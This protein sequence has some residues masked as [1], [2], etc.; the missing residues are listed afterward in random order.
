MGKP[1]VMAVHGAKKMRKELRAADL[2]LTDLKVPYA[3]AAKTIEGVAKPRTPRRSGAL[4]GTVRSSGTTTAGIVRAGN[5]TKVP[6]AQVIHWGWKA[7]RIEAQPW[8]S[9]AAQSSEPQ[10]VREFE[11]QLDEAISQIKGLSA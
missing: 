10:W 6:Y 5:N 2:K 7:H 4:M 1:P 11:E 8:L 3:N 9:D